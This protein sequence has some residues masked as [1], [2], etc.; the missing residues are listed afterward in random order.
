MIIPEPSLKYS[1]TKWYVEWY[2]EDGSRQRTYRGLQVKD[3]A[4]R[5]R[6]ADALIAKIKHDIKHR[7][8]LDKLDKITAY[9]ETL[10]VSVTQIEKRLQK[11][12]QPNLSSGKTLKKSLLEL[13]R[14]MAAD[15]RHDS[16]NSYRS[17]V[18]QFLDWV[19]D[20][21]WSD[22][23]LADFNELKAQDYMDYWTLDKKVVNVTWN[24]TLHTIKML[25][26]VGVK[27]K[28]INRN[29]FEGISSKRKNESTLTD[30]LS[31]KERKAIAAYYKEHLP[32]QY[33]A[34]L[35]QLYCLIRP[36]ELSRLKFKDFDLKN[37]VVLI[38]ESVG[39]TK[40]FR[41]PT[42]PRIILDEFTSED[43][44]KHASDWF[45]FG[46]K[47]LPSREASGKNY[48]NM[49]HDEVLN[50]LKIN[51]KGLSWYSWKHT[52]ATLMNELL[53]P[54]DLKEQGGWHDYATMEHYLHKRKV[55]E[56]VKDIS[57]LV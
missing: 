49:L 56:G 27:K 10:Q 5:E 37:G 23:P 51:R 18:N 12:E 31:P 6:V 22:M 8:Q 48:Q 36:R 39:K 1:N 7:K 47:M 3:D 45:V 40:K 24:N 38:T 32:W 55:I 52:G 17:K 54:A 30:A 35:L 21:G 19:D 13:F 28:W 26:Q 20:K 2:D 42:I 43:F 15:I 57:A 33:K 46:K 9:L 25:F 4:E 34:L 14:F 16:I 44:A 53:T 29:P 50:V 11:M 41:T